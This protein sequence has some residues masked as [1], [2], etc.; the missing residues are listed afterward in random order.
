[1][2]NGGIGSFDKK[3]SNQEDENQNLLSEETIVISKNSVDQAVEDESDEN[4]LQLES[5]QSEEDIVVLKRYV[6]NQDIENFDSEKNLKE[7]R[8]LESKSHE[9]YHEVVTDII[10]IS[11]VH[12]EKSDED[13][14]RIRKIFI[15][16]FSLILIIQLTSI[17]L[18]MI[19]NAVESVNFHISDELLT[20]F[21]GSVF[22]ET[23]GVIGVMIGFAF[24]SKDEV[25][26]VKL[27]TA[28]INSYQKYFHGQ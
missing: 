20:V 24:A 28:V 14:K 23:L 25:K 18:F 19:F 6:N 9:N 2:G 16:A 1:M 13:K 4:T 7:I 5:N 22:V 10:K 27:L 15:K 21:I 11:K 8:G 26:I 12:L 17:I 3:L